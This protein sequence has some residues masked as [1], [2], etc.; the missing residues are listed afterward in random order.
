MGHSGT[1]QACQ[2]TVLLEAAV[3]RSTIL[4]MVTRR[5]AV[6][7]L[8]MPRILEEYYAFATLVACA[9]AQ[10]ARMFAV[11]FVFKGREGSGVNYETS[12]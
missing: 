12:R 2:R 4:S 6:E 7:P 9:G 5:A 8:A 1:C 10:P 11:P 3:E